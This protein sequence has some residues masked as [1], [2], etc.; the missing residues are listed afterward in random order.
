MDKNLMFISKECQPGLMGIK[1]SLKCH[2]IGFSFKCSMGRKTQ[3]CPQCTQ[4]PHALFLI[5][6]LCF[7]TLTLLYFFCPFSE[8][9]IN[10]WACSISS[11]VAF[12]RIFRGTC[13]LWSLYLWTLLLNAH[14]ISSSR[15]TELKSKNAAVFLCL[16]FM[17]LGLLD[18]SMI[19]SLRY[20]GLKCFL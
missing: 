18:P 10:L 7:L 6:P 1:I 3:D 17:H 12:H 19:L 20:S 8:S 2:C 13:W 16:L 14:F 5:C 4:Y 15:A 9:K 11:S